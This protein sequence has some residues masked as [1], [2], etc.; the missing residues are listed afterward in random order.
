MPGK[1]LIFKL[2][3]TITVMLKKIPNSPTGLQLV[4]P[5]MASTSFLKRKL[6]QLFDIPDYILACI[7]S[8]ST[9]IKQLFVQEEHPKST[10]ISV[11]LDLSEYFKVD[12]IT[13]K[14]ASLKIKT[15]RRIV[16]E[17]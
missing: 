9:A 7:K 8:P 13:Y 16:K 3:G 15:D 17:E 5:V 14:E 12:F 10:E 11:D 4:K 6:K 2:F 1:N